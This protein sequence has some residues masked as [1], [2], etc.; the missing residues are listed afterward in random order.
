[1][2]IELA[3]GDEVFYHHTDT[4][5]AM[6]MV[7]AMTDEDGFVRYFMRDDMPEA[8]ATAYAEAQR[9]VDDYGNERVVGYVS[10]LDTIRY[11]RDIK[12]GVRL[13][14]S[15]ERVALQPKFNTVI[16]ETLHRTYAGQL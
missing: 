4:Y 9:F 11:M 5:A 10:L 7:V 1:M 13:L 8:E 16:G 12:A 3:D 2:R 14:R 15:M 6:Q